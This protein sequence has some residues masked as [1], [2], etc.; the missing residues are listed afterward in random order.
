MATGSTFMGELSLGGHSSS[1][2]LPQKRPFD[3]VQRRIGW[4]SSEIGA[5]VADAGGR[6]LDPRHSRH[7]GIRAA[8][9]IML[10]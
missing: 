6:G 1:S 4:E 10:R 8:L 3:V 5:V 2:L 7:S 9:H